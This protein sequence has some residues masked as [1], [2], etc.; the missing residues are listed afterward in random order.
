MSIPVFIERL[1]QVQIHPNDFEW[2][3]KWL[4]LYSTYLN[5]SP[6][7]LEISESLLLQFLRRLRDQGAPAWKRLQ[8]ARALEW[9]Q[10]LVL[11]QSLVDFAPFKLKLAELANVEKRAGESLNNHEEHGVPGEGLPGIIDPN[12]PQPIQAMRSR[13]RVLHHPRA[14]EDAYVGWLQRFIRHVDHENLFKCGEKEIGEFLTDL[15]VVG[16]VYRRDAKPSFMCIDVL[17]R[18]SFRKGLAVHPT[19]TGQS[20]HLPARGS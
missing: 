9:Y 5:L 12:E 7:R 8:A 4:R 2:M 19:H 6:E 17:L 10:S 16:E 13:M 14:T 20:Q 1:K 11:A 18:K 15:A 3:P